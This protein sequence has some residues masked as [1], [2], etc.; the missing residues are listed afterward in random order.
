M[1]V[2]YAHI[3]TNTLILENI[4]PDVRYLNLRDAPLRKYNTNDRS[5]RNLARALLH[6]VWRKILEK[7]PLPHARLH[8]RMTCSIS[9]TVQSLSSIFSNPTMVLLL[10]CSKCSK[11]YSLF[12]NVLMTLLVSLVWLLGKTLSNN[13]SQW[14]LE[15]RTFQ[16]SVPV[17]FIV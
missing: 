12:Q 7:T 3:L 10:Q 2:L 16:F 9:K 17:H 14:N 11:S 5:A 4:N 13:E 1:H 8:W 15:P 6:C